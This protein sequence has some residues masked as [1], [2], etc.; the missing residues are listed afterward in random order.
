LVAITF[1]GGVGEIGGNKIL[2]EDRDTRIFLDFGMSF[3]ERGKF[4][5]D[6]WL[7]PR[8]ERGLL[9]FGILPEIDGIYHFDEKPPSVDAVFLSHAHADHSM[10]ASFLKHEIP[11]YC[12]RTAASI[13]QAV[14][15][16]RPR[17]FETDLSEVSFRTFETGDRVRVGS[18]EIEPVHVDHSIP[19]S[20]GFIVHTSEGPIVYSGD[21]RIHGSRPELTR[22]F[23]KAASRERPIAMLCEGTNMIGGNLAAEEDV[24]ARLEKAV[25]STSKLVI[26]NFTHTDVDRWKSFL[27]VARGSGRQMAVS[28][29]QAHMLEVL[30]R[31]GALGVPSPQSGELLIYKRRK[32]TYYDWEKRLLAYGNVVDAEDVRKK[33]EKVILA[34]FTD[35]NELIQITPEPGS[36]FILSLSEP[37]NEEMELEY[38]RLINWLDHF[39]LPMYHIHCS[40][41]IMP[42]DIK[43]IA[44][45]VRPKKLLPIHTDHPRLFASF[46][47]QVTKVELPVRGATIELA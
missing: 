15:E 47:S 25:M 32:K 46:I 4:F 30:H 38:D 24:R 21:L 18:M 26:G 33:Q 35:P 27:D 45:E 3:S 40:G 23:V 42:N 13:L 44:S 2:I 29:R 43:A 11:I 1:Y 19:S 16:S 28:L 41:H 20:Y 8:D 10:H 17:I 9:R 14:N 22:D 12:G 36:C 7:S 31:D 34:P 6:P 39:G 37:F 5:S